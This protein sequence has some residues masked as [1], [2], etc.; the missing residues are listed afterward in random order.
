MFGVFAKST[1]R[2]SKLHSTSTDDPA[3]KEERIS[4]ITHKFVFFLRIWASN[5]RILVWKLHA[6]LSKL[7]STCTKEQLEKKIDVGEKIYCFFHFWILFKI[8]SE[9][10]QKN[11]GTVVKTVFRVY[12]WCFRE[13]R[14]NL[15]NNTYTFFGN[16]RVNFTE[17][18]ASF[19]HGCQNCL[20]HVRRKNSRRSWYWGKKF[21][22][23]ITFEF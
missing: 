14:T 11:F 6:Q 17:F 23:F 2:W 20:L 15:F 4:W 16:S 22:V 18:G 21:T 3:E 13:R 9:F 8:C 10:L 7:H 5:L 1:A 12:R 19:M